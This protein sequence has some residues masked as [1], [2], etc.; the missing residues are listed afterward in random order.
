MYRCFI[1][2]TNSLIKRLNSDMV[3]APKAYISFISA[4]YFHHTYAIFSGIK[5][6]LVPSSL[7]TCV[8]MLSCSMSSRA[9]HMLW[10][11]LLCEKKQKNWESMKKKKIF[12]GMQSV[13]FQ[14][15]SYHQSKHQGWLLFTVLEQENTC[16]LYMHAFIQGFSIILSTVAL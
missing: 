12:R 4:N 7:F 2:M 9:W 6:Y 13:K 11:C 5:I 15:Y 16:I 1:C 3:Y 8:F 14:A 10:C